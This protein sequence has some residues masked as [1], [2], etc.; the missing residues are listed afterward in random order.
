[1]NKDEYKKLLYQMIFNRVE[2]K[3]DDEFLEK[4][5]IELKDTN[6]LLKIYLTLVI[7]ILNI[8]NKVKL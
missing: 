7:Q 4:F 2:K 6:Q 8:I 5:N 3:Y 1:M